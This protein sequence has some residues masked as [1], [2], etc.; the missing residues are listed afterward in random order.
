LRISTCACLQQRPILDARRVF[1]TCVHSF[2][3]FTLDASLLQT[4]SCVFSAPT[5][6]KKSSKRIL[7]TESQHAGIQDEPYIAAFR[8]HHN[9]V[10]FDYANYLNDDNGPALQ[11]AQHNRISA[12]CSCI[13][14]VGIRE[15]LTRY[16][17]ARENP[18]CMA[19]SQTGLFK[20][21]C[22]TGDEQCL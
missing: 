16:S 2:D 18:D 10:Q 14:C 1:D 5:S 22:S 9:R 21:E 7:I 6:R 15:F 12:E 4:G 8:D 19:S 20:P 3:I 11:R 17:I 13:V